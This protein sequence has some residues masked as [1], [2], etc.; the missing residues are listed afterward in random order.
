[1]F[2]QCPCLCKTFWYDLL[3]RAWLTP[4]NAL[5]STR[6]IA[7]RIR[8]LLFTQYQRP[9]NWAICVPLLNVAEGHQND[10]DS[11]DTYDFLLE[12]HSNCGQTVALSCNAS[13][14]KHDFGQKKT[15]FIYHCKSCLCWGCYRWNF[16]TSFVFKNGMMD[17]PNGAKSLMTDQSDGQKSHI[18]IAPQCADNNKKG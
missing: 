3:T 18:N 1:M 6:I 11:S 8:L 7:C 10:T 4:N 14:I 5:L 12:I 15:N 13:K 9:K 16:L 2:V 17:L